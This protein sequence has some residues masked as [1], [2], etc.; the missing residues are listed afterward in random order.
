MTK[1]ASMGLPNFFLK[2]LTSFLCQRKQPVQIGSVNSEYTTVNAS[3]LQG[4]IFGPI[5]FLH[6]INDLQTV[7]VHVKY[8]DDCTIWEATSSSGIDSSLQ[9]AA[10]EVEQ[11]TASNKMALTYDKTKELRICFN[12]SVDQ[13]NKSKTL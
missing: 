2:W 5:G 12:K 4:K 9:V 3:V 7:C 11:W 13:S 1:C 10:D 8:V 6:H